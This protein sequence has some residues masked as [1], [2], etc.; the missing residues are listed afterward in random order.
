VRLLPNDSIVHDRF[1]SHPEH[2]ALLSKAA[3]KREHVRATLF[4][5]RREW[6]ML[7]CNTGRRPGEQRLLEFS[8]IDSGAWVLASPK[9][10]PGQV[11]REELP[12]PIYS[13]TA[14]ASDALLAQMQKKHSASDFV[15][16]RP[17]GKPGRRLMNS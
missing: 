11:P 13:I 1:L 9:Q 7:A 16:H 2:A 12:A 17:D 14:T 15:F 3:E 8:D 6:I 4:N 5:D 10:A